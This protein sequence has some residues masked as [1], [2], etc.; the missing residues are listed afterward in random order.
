MNDFDE[1]KLFSPTQMVL[2]LPK[3]IWRREIEIVDVI[4][5]ILIFL[6]LTWHGDTI[7]QHFIRKIYRIVRSWQK[8]EMDAYFC[9]QKI[10]QFVKPVV[11]SDKIKEFS[12]IALWVFEN[13][14]VTENQFM[15]MVKQ[16][17]YV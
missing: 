16:A 1:N 13:P 3:L 7:N 9:Q 8:E 14:D 12:K 15:F 5:M 17:E 6:T 2:M 10:I 4:K 11:E